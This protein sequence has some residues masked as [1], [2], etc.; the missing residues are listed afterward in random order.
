MYITYVDST[1]GEQQTSYMP[2]WI[3]GA[4]QKHRNI[5]LYNSSHASRRSCGGMMFLG[6]TASP[7]CIYAIT[8]VCGYLAAYVPK[9]LQVNLQNRR[10]RAHEHLWL[11]RAFIFLLMYVVSTHPTSLRLYTSFC[12]ALWHVSALSITL[13]VHVHYYPC[14]CST[15]RLRPC[16]LTR[17][18]AQPSDDG[19]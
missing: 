19:L 15:H 11:L 1:T 6:L 2:I 4:L 3:N 10:H 7:T 16:E 12:T 13:Y 18:F 14:V 9:S 8:H 5:I 17:L